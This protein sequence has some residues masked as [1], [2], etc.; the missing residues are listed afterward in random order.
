MGVV[1]G[2]IDLD[3][4]MRVVKIYNKKLVFKVLGIYVIENY[5][6]VRY[7]MYW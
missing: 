7:Y 6:V 3:C 1:Y 5:L 4:L 2:Y